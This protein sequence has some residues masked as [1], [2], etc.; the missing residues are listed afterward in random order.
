[1]ISKKSS[2]K[3]SHFGDVAQ[4]GIAL[5]YQSCCCCC[6]VH[7][8]AIC[9]Q[10]IASNIISWMQLLQP[11]SSLDCRQLLTICDGFG[12][13]TGAHVSCCNAPLLSTG[14]AVAMVGLE[15]TYLASL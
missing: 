1:M 14:C 4:P 8:R 5:V 7:L 13:A 3:A 12:I 15:A 6:R 9:L 11:P 10:S 2:A